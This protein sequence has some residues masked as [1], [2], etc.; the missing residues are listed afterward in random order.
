[1]YGWIESNISAEGNNK[2]TSDITCYK[3]FPH[4]SR[5]RKNYSFINVAK[6]IMLTMSFKGNTF[7]LKRSAEKKN[8]IK[9]INGG[10]LED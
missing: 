1:M 2:I 8:T 7:Q 10:N 3:I 6:Q 4:I 9:N 5:L